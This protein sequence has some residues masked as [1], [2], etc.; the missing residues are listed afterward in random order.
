[1][2]LKVSDR[3]LIALA[4]LL[5]LA[6]CAGIAA[7]VIF[8]VDMVAKAEKVFNSNSLT[9][10]IA[11]C[12]LIAVFLVF[13]LYCILV[14]FYHRKGDRYVTQ[15][16]ENGELAISIS[17]LEEMVRACVNQV[18]ELKVERTELTSQKDGLLIRLEG[19]VA[20]GVSIP[21]TVEALQKQI[22]QYVV[23][24]SGA[25][26]KSIRVE[27]D[28]TGETVPNAPFAIEPPAP[29]P[30]LHEADPTVEVQENSDTAAVTETET[31]SVSAEPDREEKNTPIIADDED[32]DR[33]LHQRLFSHQ[34][35]PCIVPEPPADISDDD[36]GKDSD[37]SLTED[38][39]ISSELEEITKNPDGQPDQSVNPDESTEKKAEI[40]ENENPD[41]AL[42]F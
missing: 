28:S 29:T 5:L 35:E 33:P 15:K 41:P 39:V 26:I 38:A 21:L 19:Q 25:D 3:I 42:E 2:K 24:C 12:A 23:A 37:Q 14:L 17:A 6:C 13:G 20:S 36:T 40:S 4:G 34:P 22:R 10:T 32:D 30:L 8:G 1:M 7:Q 11:L 9:V 31:D 18:P 27:I 16:N